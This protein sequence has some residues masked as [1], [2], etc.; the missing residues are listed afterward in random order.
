[1]SNFKLRSQRFLKHV[2]EQ[3]IRKT[4][5]HGRQLR[6]KSMEIFAAR[7]GYS[8]ATKRAIVTLEK[9]QRSTI[10]GRGSDKRTSFFRDFTILA[11]R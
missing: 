1:M 3:S 6:E 9:M 8:K 7:L 5:G 2:S 10:Q 11:F 4:K